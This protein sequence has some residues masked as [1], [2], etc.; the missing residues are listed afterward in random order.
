MNRRQ[1]LKFANISLLAAISNSCGLSFSDRAMTIIQL[2]Q[3][4]RRQM[5]GY[6]IVPTDK[7][8]IVIDGGHSESAPQLAKLIQGLGGQVQRWLITHPHDDHIGAFCRIIDTEKGIKVHSV[9][10]HL[11]DDAW[12]QQNGDG[13]YDDFRQL[14]DCLEK[15]NVKFIQTVSGQTIAEKD[16]SINVISD[17][18]PEITSNAYNNSSVV[19]KISDRHKSFLILGDLGVEG[20]QKLLR[21]PYGNLVEADYVQMAHHGQRGVDRDFYRQ[22][23][24]QGCFW[25]TPQWLYDNDNGNGTNSGPWDTINV[26]RWMQELGV[27]NHYVSATGLHKVT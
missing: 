22:V 17:P 7:K 6:V 14:T 21:G 16:I 10:G 1:L 3:F 15:R 12:A 27:K 13:R 25:P 19:Y 26:R 2:P 18:N 23:K 8:L 9:H 24:P 11:F 4:G 20:G 5:M